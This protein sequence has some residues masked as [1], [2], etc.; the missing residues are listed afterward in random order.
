[1]GGDVN[2]YRMVNN[3]TNIATDA[4]G[5]ACYL[6]GRTFTPMGLAQ[7]VSERFYENMIEK[8]GGFTVGVAGQKVPGMDSYMGEDRQDDA[9]LLC[10]CEVSKVG[11]MWEQTLK[12]TMTIEDTYEC[13]D[14]R[15]DQCDKTTTPKK[16]GYTTSYEKEII[17]KQKDPRYMKPK[18]IY[19]G[20]GAATGSGCACPMVWD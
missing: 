15:K 18:V 20:L 5:L 4:F 3:S 10:W 12:Q 8:T 11:E 7:L 1:M 9:D 2:L 6:V 19:S 16:G 17:Y 14:D 13:T